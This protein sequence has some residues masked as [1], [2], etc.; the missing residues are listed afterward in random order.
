FFYGKE[1]ST[2]QGDQQYNESVQEKE[3]VLRFLVPV[4]F[5]CR[6]ENDFPEIPMGRC[7]SCQSSRSG[8]HAGNSAQR[9][10]A[11]GTVH[12]R[13]YFFQVLKCLLIHFKLLCISK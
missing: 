2:G 4:I 10:K 12:D 6:I 8:D 11:C 3:T 1:N 5:R 9:N 13:P 7:S